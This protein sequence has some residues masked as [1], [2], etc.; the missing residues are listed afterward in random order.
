MGAGELVFEPLEQLEF[1]H[2]T[3]GLTSWI[4][5]VRADRVQWFGD[6]D[7]L[8]GL[9]PGGFSGRFDDYLARLHPEDV[10]AA[11][12]T[13]VDCLKGRLAAWRSEE[14]LV[15][16][17]G[18]MRWLETFGR[19]EQAGERVV[20]M[21]G[22][23]R[24]ITGRRAAEERV[25]ELND[26]LEERVRLRTRELEAANRDL[27]GFS[28]AV[29]HD[30]RAPAC[31]LGNFAAL[32][33]AECAEALGDT[34]R[35]YVRRIRRIA[36]RLGEMIDGLLE[37]SRAGRASLATAPVPL[38]RIAAEL[39]EELRPACRYRG[40]VAIGP[41][42]D[43]SGDARLLRQ[44]VQNLI[45]NAMKFSRDADSPLV[46]VSSRRLLAGGVEYCVRDNGC[47]FDMKHARRLFETFQRLHAAERYEGT[48][49]GLATVRRIVERHGGVVRAEGEPG[50]GAAF[51]FT[52]PA[53]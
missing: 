6:P 27:D 46:E 21:A 19:A 28:L 45:A 29:S 30:L 49:V 2:R 40:Q 51:Y 3:A 20:R 39:A 41:V 9:P 42:H 33:E 24:D 31:T 47:G 38:G 26:R 43:A 52:L 7:A 8:L 5:E 4:W 16:P 11:K 14:R 32:L 34:G 23:V 37:F 17:D 25:R 10:A 18:S 36:S 12:R 1:V 44:V 53:A 22:V 13:Y 50:R 35:Q 48:G 15:R